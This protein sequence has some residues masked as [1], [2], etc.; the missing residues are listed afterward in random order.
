MINIPLSTTIFGKI[1]SIEKTHK[2]Y[3]NALDLKELP[4][5]I[6]NLTNVKY[7]FLDENKL[8]YLPTS[9]GGLNSLLKLNLINNRLTNL[10]DSIGDLLN[11]EHLNLSG[12]KITSLPDSIGNLKKIKYLLLS[13]NRLKYLPS[14]MENLTSLQNLYLENNQLKIIPKELLKKKRTL[15]INESSY[16]INNLDEECEFII[17]ESLTNPINNLPVN[18]KEIW[19]NTENKI[20]VNK[21]KIPFNCQLCYYGCCS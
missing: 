1:Y 7:M 19:L 15:I 16:E 21:I 14:S 5:E 18:L 13:E 6:G 2:I 9:M 11:L 10:P 12:N 8:T 20:N 17:L 3:L 4:D